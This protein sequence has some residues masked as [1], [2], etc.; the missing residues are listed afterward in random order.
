MKYLVLIWAGLWRKPARTVL[1]S[2]SIVT[3]FLLYGALDGTM[4]S[5]NQVIHQITGDSILLT[6]S[7]VNMGTG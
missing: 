5:F 6:V 3:A 2:L 1:T 4:A 7:R